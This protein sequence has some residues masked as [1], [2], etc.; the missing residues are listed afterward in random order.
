M[1]KIEYFFWEGSVLKHHIIMNLQKHK[2][3]ETY[4][5]NKRENLILPPKYVPNLK[6]LP[7]SEKFQKIM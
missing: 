5:D 4:L 3:W 2:V 6:V 1:K 7:I